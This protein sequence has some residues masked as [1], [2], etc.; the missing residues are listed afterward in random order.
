MA[1]PIEC[2][3]ELSADEAISFIDNWFNKPRNAA[4]D[5]TIE[6]ARNLNIEVRI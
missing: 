2:V 5:A 6:R 3:A 4:R 1:K